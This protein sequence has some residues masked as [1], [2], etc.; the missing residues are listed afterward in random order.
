MDDTLFEALV[1]PEAGSA[2]FGGQFLAQAL[3]AAQHT[4]GG[5]RVVHSL[6]AIL[7]RRRDVRLPV[8]LQVERVRDG[9]AFCSR[10]VSAWQGGGSSSA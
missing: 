2:L 9:R 6:R 10:Q 3:R 7:L 5:D 4:T 1:S 8:E